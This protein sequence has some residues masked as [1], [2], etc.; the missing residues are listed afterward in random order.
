M[1]NQNSNKGKDNVTDKTVQDE[2]VEAIEEAQAEQEAKTSAKESE[3]VVDETTLLKDEL[4][5]T[6]KALAEAKDQSLRAIAELQNAQR[7]ARQDVE[8]AHKFALDKFVESLLPVVDSL[9]R[10]LA[11]ESS[12]KSALAMKEGI[13]LTL[14]LFLDTLKKFNVDQVC[15][16][17]EPFNPELHQAVSQ[18]ENPDVEP[19]TVTEVFQKGYVLNKRLVRPAMVIVAK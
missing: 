3:A 17:G 16:E 11:T 4:T 18:I 8:K 7:R 9:E 19:G 10:G 1:T 14:K 15:P 5:K 13:D 6:Q 2:I 12:D